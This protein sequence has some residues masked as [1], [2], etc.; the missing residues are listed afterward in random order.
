[1]IATAKRPR[2]LQGRE[3]EIETE[4]GFCGVP[5]GFA[6]Y[7]VQIG[8]IFLPPHRKIR[9]VSVALEPIMTSRN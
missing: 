1:M 5:F 8:T 9:M 7:H 6:K 2:R 3:T 4:S